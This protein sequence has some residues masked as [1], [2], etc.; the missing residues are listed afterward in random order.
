MYTKT[1]DAGE[2]MDLWT[3]FIEILIEIWIFSFKKMHL[4]M[5]SGNQRPFCLGLNVLTI[6]CCHVC[7]SCEQSSP[8]YNAFS[9]TFHSN[10]SFVQIDI[11]HSRYSGCY[12]TSFM[13]LGIQP[14]AVAQSI[15]MMTKV[16]KFSSKILFLY[17]TKVLPI[18]FPLIWFYSKNSFLY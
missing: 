15:T 12:N 17:I 3:N 4:K 2:I 7:V 18:I 6:M 16:K 5:P 14:I 9:K 8:C 1:I 13:F 10:Y 11:I